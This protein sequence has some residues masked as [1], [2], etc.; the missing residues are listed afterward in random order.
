MTDEPETKSPKL[1]AFERGLARRRARCQTDPA[2]FFSAT[3]LNPERP[4]EGG[5]MR[6]AAHQR[7]GF[8]FMEAHRRAVLRWPTDT[9]KTIS[10]VAYLLWKLGKNPNLSALL[11]GK[12]EDIAKRSF[13]HVRNYLEEPKLLARVQMT[14]PELRLTE[15]DLAAR[16]TT[17][18]TVER[19]EG[20]PDPSMQAIGLY[21]A[22]QG[23]KPSL[24]VADDLLDRSNTQTK[25]QRRK[26]NQDFPSQLV[27]RLVSDEGSVYLVNVPWHED[28]LTFWLEDEEQGWP[29]LHFDLLGNVRLANTDWT[30]P[31]LRESEKRPGEYRL[32]EHDSPEYAKYAGVTPPPGTTE[33]FDADDQVPLF[34][35]RWPNERIEDHQHGKN[36]EPPA[37]F[38][39]SRL[40]KPK[41]D[42]E[43]RCH[44][45]WIDG[46]Y[47]EQTE[48]T[49]P[50]CKFV[51]TPVQRLD[52]DRMG[53]LPVYVGVDVAWGEEEQ[54]DL[55]AFGAI[56]IGPDAERL[57]LNIESERVMTGPEVIDRLIDIDERYEPKMFEVESVGAQKYLLQFARKQ[58]ASIK[59]HGHYTT[60]MSKA[61]KYTG[62]EAL[63]TEFALGLWRIPASR[64][65]MCTPEIQAF[66]QECLDYRPGLHPG[67][68]L[69]AVLL[70]RKAAD[71]LI[72]AIDRSGGKAK[73]SP[74]SDTAALQGM[75]ARWGSGNSYAFKRGGGGGGF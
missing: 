3:F 14:F 48:E 10:L 66:I 21:T 28:D 59:V 43:Q 54:S 7:V 64:N 27:S 73:A 19:P 37:E 11:A 31:L 25:A 42:E 49:Y 9:G 72:R 71:R 70:A 68:R 36:R 4:N 61:D 55:N 30:T 39:R 44:I 58:K 41:S 53:R 13:R 57:L 51:G 65:R 20:S 62:I 26:M 67:D 74:K 38:S 15:S 75:N 23:K 35:E 34:P 32:A 24:I 22:A 50:G 47:D 2:A 69:I 5:P 29:V 1:A 56:G 17:S 12:I 63:F 45:Q 52:E 60:K 40:C 6:C 8:A 46:G 18:I 16:T 33:W